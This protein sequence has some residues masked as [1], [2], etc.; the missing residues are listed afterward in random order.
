MK[1]YLITM[2]LGILAIACSKDDQTTLG[3]DGIN[4]NLSMVE[5]LQPDINTRRP[6]YSQEALQN[7]NKMD[8]YIF[9]QSGADYFYS[10]TYNISWV[11]GNAT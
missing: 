5:M 11:Q 3:G 8:L 2:V 7:V 1:N 10:T 9:R 4:I 6:V